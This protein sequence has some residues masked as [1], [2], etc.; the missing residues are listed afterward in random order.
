MSHDNENASR[1]FEK[2]HKAE[3]LRELRKRLF[4]H[5]PE[6]ETEAKQEL[7]DFCVWDCERLDITSEHGMEAHFIASFQI[8]EPISNCPGFDDMHTYHTQAN[9]SPDIVSLAFLEKMQRHT[10]LQ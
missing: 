4:D 6:Y 8:G 2:I 10:E 5:Y 1:K 9:G 7:F 3:F